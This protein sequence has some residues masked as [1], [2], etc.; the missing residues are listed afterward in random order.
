MTCRLDEK[1]RILYFYRYKKDRFAFS[2]ELFRIKVFTPS[3]WKEDKHDPKYAV[4]LS[5]GDEAVCV[6]LF[7]SEQTLIDPETVKAA[8]SVI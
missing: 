6:A 1:N 8:Y 5:S 7:S 2:E 4:V 3:E